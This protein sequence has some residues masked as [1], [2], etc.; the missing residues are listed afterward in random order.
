[1]VYYSEVAKTD[2]RNALWGLA[3]WVKHPLSYEHAAS[4]VSDVRKDADTICKK[5]YHRR[6]T[7]EQHLKHGE[8]IHVYKRNAKT[9]WYII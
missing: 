9:Q 8:K 2:L 5:R 7:S 1:M 3:N 4:Y 6:C